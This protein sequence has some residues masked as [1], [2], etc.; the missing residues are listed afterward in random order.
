MIL[1]ES[2]VISAFSFLSTLVMIMLVFGIIDLYCN[3]GVLSLNWVV[4]LSLIGVI[5][6]IDFL[7]SL[8]TYFRAVKTNPRKQLQDVYS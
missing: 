6:L 2:S 4:L 8:F 5:L 7:V 1:T 3:A